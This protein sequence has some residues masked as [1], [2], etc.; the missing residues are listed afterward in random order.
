MSKKHKGKQRLP[1]FGISL[2]MTLF[3]VGMVVLLPLA[4]L[5]ISLADQSPTAILAELSSARTLAAFRLSFGSALMAAGINSIFGLV[6][7]WALV[8]YDFPGRTFLDAVVDLPF[9]LPTAIS[10]ITLTSLFVPDGWFG[11]ILGAFGLKLAFNQGGIVLALVFI[12]IPFAVRT[13][14]PALQEMDLAQEEMA[15]S[16][17]ANR[18]QTFRM[19]LLPYLLAPLFAAF[20]LTFARAIGEYGSVIFIAGNLPMKTEVAPLLMVIELEQFNK[21][22]ATILGFAL[23]VS[24]LAVIS[25]VHGMQRWSL[26]RALGGAV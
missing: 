13:L 8:R 18:W 4:A 24:A 2:G 23:L 25:L 22:G 6:V 15:A 3:Y 11:Q 17:G 26:R 10:G 5:C 7:A 9:A 16:L 19:I 1:G 12:G 21:G 14:Q 20:G